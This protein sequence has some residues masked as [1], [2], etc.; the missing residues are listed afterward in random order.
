MKWLEDRDNVGWGGEGVTFHSI[1]VG[2]LRFL[3]TGKSDTRS[4]MWNLEVFF[5][6]EALIRAFSASQQ[7]SCFLNLL[8]I[9][10][11]QG[12]QVEG[13]LEV[14]YYPDYSSFLYLQTSGTREF[15]VCS[16]LISK[17]LYYL[18][19]YSLLYFHGSSSRLL[20]SVV[21]LRLSFAF[22]LSH[23]SNM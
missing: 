4:K 5:F 23:P 15:L 12:S 18:D 21:L 2:F 8:F 6:Y 14:S 22:L 1:M 17:V 11:T 9:F 3:Y 7:L 13:P 20:Q 19:F 10:Y 16:T